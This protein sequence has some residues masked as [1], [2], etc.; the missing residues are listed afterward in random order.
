MFRG[1]GIIDA[2][3]ETDYKK[4]Q[5]NQILPKHPTALYENIRECGFNV[6]MKMVPIFRDRG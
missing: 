6:S 3:E 2:M 4:T 1:F 5:P